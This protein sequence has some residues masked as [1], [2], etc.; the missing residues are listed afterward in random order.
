M[1]HQDKIPTYANDMIGSYAK[2][3][4]L[5]KFNLFVA[6]IVVVSLPCTFYLLLTNVILKYT[7]L[8]DVIGPILEFDGTILPKFNA[9]FLRVKNFCDGLLESTQC[10][11]TLMIHNLTAASIIFAIGLA[12]LLTELK[13][14]TKILRHGI[15][16]QGRFNLYE[17][18]LNTGLKLEARRND[19][20][21]YN[22][23]FGNAKAINL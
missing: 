5:L 7:L 12:Y 23:H 10:Y 1:E 19:E 22:S 15:I 3:R 16:L 6:L 17:G 11:K 18:R 20:A 4:L 8:S 9:G 13:V 2:A 14:V 21:E